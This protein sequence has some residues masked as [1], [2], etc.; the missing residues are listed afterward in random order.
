MNLFKNNNETLKN[1]ICN[2]LKSVLVF[3]LFAA[4]T[5]NSCSPDDPIDPD[6]GQSNP[7]GFSTILA[8][9]TADLPYL[10]N[11]VKNFNGVAV[12]VPYLNTTS[13]TS[14]Q[15]SMASAIRPSNSSTFNIN[16]EVYS[17]LNT[18]SDEIYSYDFVS[19]ALMN[20]VPVN[21]PS[22]V[23]K[24]S[25]LVYVNNLNSYYMVEVEDDD[26]NLN[27]PNQSANTKL[28]LVE[29][30]INTGAISP[31]AISGDGGG[32][33]LNRLTELNYGG[34]SFRN[35]A[36]STA[37]DG[38]SKIYILASV[39]MIEVDLI[40]NTS[41][42]INLNTAS[43]TGP[44]DPSNVTDFNF[45]YFGLE[46]NYSTG[47]LVYLRKGGFINSTYSLEIVKSNPNSLN[48][49][50][51]FSI[52]HDISSAMPDFIEEFYSTVID[53]RAS[54]S[55]YVVGLFNSPNPIIETRF[56]RVDLGAPMVQL[57]T[58]QNKYVFG[59]ESNVQ[60]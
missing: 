57:S 46:Y 32:Y 11:Q 8:M 47:N 58:I 14:F 15:S 56:C 18:E 33:I 45:K 38:G 27:P 43:V 16:T 9:E 4:S 12:D 36:V 31:V 49:A 40:T 50:S 59:M 21:N 22:L 10:S 55:Q 23:S 30:D 1:R 25:G 5:L 6:T 52:Y 17:F 42:I 20:P 24:Y 19:A 39:F 48:T 2:T 54:D 29:V 41:L 60:N 13:N 51:P 37:T 34:T 7:C 26:N 35:T 3:T 44:N 28:R 53:C